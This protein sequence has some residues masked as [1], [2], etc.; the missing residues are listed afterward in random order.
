MESTRERKDCLSWTLS[1]NVVLSTGQRRRHWPANKTTFLKCVLSLLY[2]GFGNFVVSC[3]AQPFPNSARI[4]PDFSFFWVLMVVLFT[5][6]N[7]PEQAPRPGGGGVGG[8]VGVPPPPRPFLF[9]GAFEIVYLVYLWHASDTRGPTADWQRWAWPR[10]A[11]PGS[12]LLV[13]RASPPPPILRWSSGVLNPP[14]YKGT[15]GG[16]RLERDWHETNPSRWQHLGK[17]NNF[18][19]EGRRISCSVLGDH[20]EEVV[21]NLSC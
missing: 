4:E 12:T 16:C 7:H 10:D 18:A 8:E 19:R 21:Q 3:K 1:P 11:R 20:L 17:I 6:V 15:G 2:M 13:T 9:T 14:V 5:W